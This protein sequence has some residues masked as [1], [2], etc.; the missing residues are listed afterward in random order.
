MIFQAKA[1][2]PTP[3]TLRRKLRRRRRAKKLSSAEDGGAL[4]VRIG[5]EISK[6][7]KHFS[8]VV[9]FYI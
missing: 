6:K 7:F 2:K 1:M 3:G 8:S 5:A 9:K 4:E